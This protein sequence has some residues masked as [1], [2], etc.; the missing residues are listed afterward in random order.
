M[1]MEKYAVL[2][3]YICTLGHKDFYSGHVAEKLLLDMRE[4]SER[5]IIDRLQDHKV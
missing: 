5:E 4:K 1:K 2:L 3:R